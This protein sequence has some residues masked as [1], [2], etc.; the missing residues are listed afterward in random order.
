M[1]SQ[2]SPTYAFISTTSTT[3][4]P[5]N[6]LE[7]AII[8]N[9]ELVRR[10]RRKTSARELE[11]LEMAFRE[12]DKPSKEVREEIARKTGMDGKAVQVHIPLG[13]CRKDIASQ[14]Q[15]VWMGIDG[16]YGF[17]ISDSHCGDYPN[18]QPQLQEHWNLPNLH[19]WD[20]CCSL[21]KF[22]LCC[23]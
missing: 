22:L 5:E 2:A 15:S 9:P 13:S 7:N 8:D 3:Y 14:R 23:P 18:W 1:D 6:P 11:V 16:R 20:P 4:H 19:Y 21:L 12:C 10:R 17:R